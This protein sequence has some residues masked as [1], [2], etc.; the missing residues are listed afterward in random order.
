[1][2]YILVTGYGYICFDRTL[3]SNSYNIVTNNIYGITIEND[4]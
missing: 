4:V 1:M 2:I 3:L